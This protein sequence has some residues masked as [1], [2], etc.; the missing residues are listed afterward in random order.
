MDLNSLISDQETKLQANLQVESI[1]GKVPERIPENVPTAH[2]QLQLDRIQIEKMLS[3]LYVGYDT[4]IE[5]YD[6][7]SPSDKWRRRSVQEF[8]VS[9]QIS[10]LEGKIDEQA[11]IV[12]NGENEHAREDALKRV[13]EGMEYMVG[14]VAWKSERKVVV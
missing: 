4:L 1:T 5:I 3:V 10:G 7:I 2:G 11:L 9:E 8:M 13:E 6:S 12:W 14:L